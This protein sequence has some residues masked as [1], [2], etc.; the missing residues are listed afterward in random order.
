MRLCVLQANTETPHEIAVKIA[1]R[2]DLS[3]RNLALVTLHAYPALHKTQLCTI[4]G[5]VNETKAT[6]TPTMGLEHAIASHAT[7][8]V[9]HEEVPTLINE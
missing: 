2:A 9:R 7:L 8:T 3:V 6:M 5:P 1:T 4:V